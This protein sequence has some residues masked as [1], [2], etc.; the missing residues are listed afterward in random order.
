M[1][2]PLEAESQMLSPRRSCED[3]TRV[4][5]V[6]PFDPFG[7]KI[8]GIQTFL[9]GFV[10]YSPSNF[11]IRL[12]GTSTNVK[13]RPPGRSQ[14]IEVQG[15]QIE[16]L[17]ILHEHHE[18]VKSRFPLSLRFTAALSTRKVR[19]FCKGQVLLF[20]R[21]EPSLV[22][23][24]SIGPR[25]GFVHNDINDALGRNSESTWH[26][27]P[28]AYRLLERWLIHRFDEVCVV[29]S[30]TYRIYENAYPS[31]IGRLTFLPTWVDERVF[32][33]SLVPAAILRKELPISVQAPDDVHWVLFVGRF[34]E[35]KDPLLLIRAFALLA[36]NYPKASLLLVGEGNLRTGMEDV[37]KKL[38]VA[39]KIVFLGFLDQATLARLYQCA[40]VL[41]LTS[42]FEGMPRSVVE[43]V[44]TGL[45]VVTIRVGEV[46]RVVISGKTG[47]V[48]PNRD[49]RAIADAIARVFSMSSSF[50]ISDFQTAVEDYRPGKVLSPLYEMCRALY[51]QASF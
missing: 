3:F 42:H 31:M 47:F 16:F 39:E 48:V 28:D 13:K 33:P 7:Q 6:Y 11:Q 46:E 15:R 49:P 23:P 38:G 51:K 24:L 27:M 2:A 30:N 10:R 36:R 14:F 17:P 12:L 19:A 44:G 32:Q 22:F 5:I 37:A 9:R 29:N 26:I 4:A 25:I 34:Q 21:I 41:V 20:N 8:G 40:D 18:N 45:P 50:A 1:D 43:A 35:Q